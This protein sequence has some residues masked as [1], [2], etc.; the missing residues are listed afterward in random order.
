MFSS[1]P[2]QPK[3]ILSLPNFIVKSILVTI[4]A[5]TAYIFYL[6]LFLA[7][8]LWT[9]FPNFLKELVKNT[10]YSSPF[11]Q[12]I[13][14]V[15]KYFFGIASKSSE[16]LRICRSEVSF[17]KY[18]FRRQSASSAPPSLSS[19]IS[20]SL[21][22][23]TRDLTGF[24][25]GEPTVETVSNIE[26]SLLYS[27]QLTLERTSIESKEC[28]LNEVVQMILYKKRF[29]NRGDPRTPEA[30]ILRQAMNKIHAS[31]KLV[32]ELNA[33]AATRYDS[34]NKSHERRLLE[35]WQLLM[36]VEKLTDRFTEQWIKI[37]FQGRD[38]ATD[39][40]GMGVL[41][42]DDLIYF[43][44]TYPTVCSAVLESSR[45]P[46]CWYSF[47]LV[48][49]NIT[50]FTLQLIRTRRLQYWLFTYNVDKVGKDLYHEFYCYLFKQFNN[51]W[52]SRNITVMEFERVFAV[53]KKNVEMDLVHRKK[54]MVLDE[55]KVR[56]WGVVETKKTL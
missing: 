31:Y 42:L 2:Q 15:W 19:S 56:S 39:F 16:L 22:R 29:P 36:P 3:R 40:R 45:H 41:S 44:K 26:R 43:A 13:Y 8:M 4:T 6:N 11:L 33:R 7:I 25:I 46:I 38:P 5:I 24:M 12:A 49:I 30:I 14:R 10:I 9:I 18:Q 1:L 52:V 47:A 20:A 34:S 55:E 17:Q 27:V 37:G 48:G 51:Y 32:Y 35:L 53:F 23:D 21:R 54:G 50:A 28:G